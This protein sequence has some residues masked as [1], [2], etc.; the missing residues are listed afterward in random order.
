M[1]KLVKQL[2][3][4]GM[5]FEELG[6]TYVGPMD[7]HDVALMQTVFRDGLRRKGPVLIHVI[8]QKGKGYGPSEANPEFYHGTG[9]LRDSEASEPVPS[10]SQ[11]FGRETGFLAKK[12]DKMVAITA[13][14]PDG[15]GLSQFKELYG[16]RFFDV[17]IAEQH[18][19]TL[20]AG[21]AAGDCGP[22]WPSIL[23]SCSVL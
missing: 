20:A 22:W 15:T 23:R 12:N 2:V 13:A 9:P 1:K 7:G 5:L 17:G 10:Y 4:P 14:M 8:T 19:V 21:L 6:F 3:V 18:A 11:V 16:Q